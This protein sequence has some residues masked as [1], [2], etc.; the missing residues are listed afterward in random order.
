MFWD[1]RVTSLETQALEPLKA[2]EE[3]RGTA[4][5]E[6]AAMDRVVARLKAIPEYVSLF[7]DAF[8][9]GRSTRTVSDE[10]SPASSARSLR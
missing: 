10:L 3:M 5:P 2:M 8:G 6:D 9:K 1:N 7:D 4:Y